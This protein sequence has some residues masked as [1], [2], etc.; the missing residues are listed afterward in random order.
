MHLLKHKLFVGLQSFQV[1]FKS[2]ISPC[3]LNTFA[4]QHVEHNL[5]RGKWRPNISK[6]LKKL[7]PKMYKFLLKAIH[8]LTDKNTHAIN[9]DL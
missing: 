1:A 9:Q 2:I 8:L 5:L 6:W 4:F 7:R 3:L